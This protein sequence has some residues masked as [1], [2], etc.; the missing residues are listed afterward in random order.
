MSPLLRANAI[1]FVLLIAHT[2]DHAVNQPPHEVP[3]ILG[4]VGLIGFIAV[5]LS[6]LLALRRS[7]QA[8]LAGMFV[9]LSTS[10]SFIAIHV[11]PSWGGLSD[12]YAEF[13]PNILSWTLMFAPIL[14]GFLLAFRGAQG[15]RSTG[16]RIA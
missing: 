6:L 11:A 9:G 16:A 13:D 10:F 7:P 5:A 15:A 1:L 2:V 8:P 4:L 14:A 12:P 3:G